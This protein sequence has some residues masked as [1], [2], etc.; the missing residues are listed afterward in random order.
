MPSPRYWRE[1]PTRFRLEAARCR[2]CGVVNYPVRLV[3][4]KCGFHF[5]ISAKER[6]ALLFDDEQWEEFGIGLSATDALDFVDQKTY[7]QRLEE[8]RRDPVPS[9]KSLR[10]CGRHART[11]TPRAAN[12]TTPST[13]LEPDH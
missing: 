8:A 4:S 2:S 3:C 6:L 10:G 9:G 13:G 11:P 12:G 5:K 7:Q 1:V